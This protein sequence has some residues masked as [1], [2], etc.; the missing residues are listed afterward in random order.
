MGSS[1][2]GSQRSAGA[3]T[4]EFYSGSCDSQPL[5]NKARARRAVSVALISASAFRALRLVAACERAQPLP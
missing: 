5:W 1:A 3:P 4:K 2:P